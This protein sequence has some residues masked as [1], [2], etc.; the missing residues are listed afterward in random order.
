[1][2]QDFGP[3]IWIADGET[4]TAAAGF[5]YPT[6]MA[7]I[8]NANGDLLIWSPVELTDEL[9]NEV[10]TLGDVQ[11]IVAPNTL[12]HVFIDQWAS[13]FPAGRVL[14][15][16][17]LAAKRPDF[18]FSAELGDTPE[19]DWATEL[20]QVIVDGN[21]ITTEVVFFHRESQTALFTDLLQQMPRRWY[22]GWRRIV[23]R[24]DL[25][26]EDEPT[27]PRK[28]RVAFRNRAA[29]RQTLERVLAWP[30][31]QVI[32]AH[33]TPVRREGRAFLERAFRWLGAG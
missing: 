32:M 11:T 14:G 6:R 24:L 2:L 3:N 17:G 30:T 1:M 31:E 33:G 7:V 19:A 28:F 8:R 18:A 25:M 9:R 5:H 26:T 4:I 13:A 10:A 16:P 29:T 27:V 12:H 15:A 22:S 20:D 23:A 21:R